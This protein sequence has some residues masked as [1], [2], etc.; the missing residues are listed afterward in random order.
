MQEQAPHETK[1]IETALKS[2]QPIPNKIQNAPELWPGLELFYLAFLELSSTRNVGFGLGPIPW[3]SMSD[4]CVAHDIEGE[5]RDDLI[6]H[7]S[8]LDLEYL[9][10]KDK[11]ESSNKSAPINKPKVPKRG[12]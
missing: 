8:H 5:Q 1:I 10:Y 4:Y 11:K 6:Y 12:R 3:T 7:V 9:K 2:G